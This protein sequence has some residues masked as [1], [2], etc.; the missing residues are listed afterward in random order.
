MTRP[1]KFEIMRI[2]RGCCGYLNHKAQ[3]LGE[4]DCA[5]F[6][7][8]R[9]LRK[10][11]ASEEEAVTQPMVQREELLKVAAAMRARRQEHW[12]DGLFRFARVAFGGPAC[13]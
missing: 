2:N 7:M 1:S 10:R 11:K 9:D 8:L 4:M 12:W 6:D 3:L 13:L 5:E